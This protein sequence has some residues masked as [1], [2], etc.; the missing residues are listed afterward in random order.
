MTKITKI[1]SQWKD[2]D[3]HSLKWFRL[4]DIE[5]RTVYE[6][7][8]NKTIDKIGPGIYKKTNTDTIYWQNGIRLL[9]EEYRKDIFVSSLSALEQQSVVHYAKLGA[10]QTVSLR[11]YS[12]AVLPSWFRNITFDSTFSFR[13][14]KLFENVQELNTVTSNGISLKVSCREQAILEFIEELDLSSSFETAIN[15][16]E[17][18]HSLRPKILQSLLENCNSIKVKRVFLYLSETLHLPYMAQLN[19]KQ[20]NL[21]RGKRSIYKNGILDPKYLITVPPKLEEGIF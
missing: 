11:T 1:L 3:L 16:M 8:K 21:G 17:L 14:S 2:G 19:L 9:Q 6:Y 5:Q 12:K 7:Y 4:F 13:Q 20:I 15:Y 18:L 10:N